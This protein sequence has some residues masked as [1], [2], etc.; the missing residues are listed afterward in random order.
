MNGRRED[1]L[2]G[3]EYWEQVERLYH[4]A[5]VRDPADREEFLNGASGAPE[6]RA[7]VRSLISAH[8]EGSSF[9]DSPEGL[10][11]ELR[12]ITAICPENDASIRGKT[13]G[14]YNVRRV[15]GRGGMGV[16]YLARDT[17]LGRNLALKL[18]RPEYTHDEERLRRL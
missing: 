10:V 3:S 4:G 16:V 9:L 13:I 8:E 5:L 14:H 15:I 1:L 11:A 6:V 7:E 12:T 17:K 18:L 2:R